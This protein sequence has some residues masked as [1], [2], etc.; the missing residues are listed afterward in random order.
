MASYKNVVCKV[1]LLAFSLY[2]RELTGFDCLPSNKRGGSQPP[3]AF[4]PVYANSILI[5]MV[6]DI[7][8]G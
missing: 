6:R 8:L 4:L 7:A 5:W 3:A 2:S 1:S